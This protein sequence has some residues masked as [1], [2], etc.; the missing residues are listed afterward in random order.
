MWKSHIE[1]RLG[2]A[3]LREL[4]PDTLERFVVELRRAGAGE[5]SIQRSLG[6]LGAMFSCA[7]SWNRMVRN[8]VAAMRKPKQ[9]RTRPPPSVLS[10]RQV[11]A[12]RSGLANGRDRLLVSLIAYAG[13]R[14]GEAIALQWGDL[15]DDVL[16]VDKSLSDGQVK[17]TKTER[18]RDVDIEP[19]LKQELL[20]HRISLGRPA[21]R[22]L[23][24]QM[25]DG[26]PWN[27]GKWRRWRDRTFEPAVAKAGL[28]PMPPYDLRHARA[29]QL[30][31]SGASVVEVADQLGHS[32]SMCL[33]TYSHVIAEFKRR[34]SIDLEAEVRAARTFQE[35][36]GDSEMAIATRS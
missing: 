35:S 14:P 5:A 20:E 33:T 31:A 21:D 18:P 1:K 16:R 24:F 9:K 4:T 12:I 7:V 2:K 19:W 27:E 8:P 23:I 11:E 25:H 32:P 15:R 10:P 6:I 29:S 30:I 3:R 13:L 28:P 22:E 26:R 34:G 36:A 17:G